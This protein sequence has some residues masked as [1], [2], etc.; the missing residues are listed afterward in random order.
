MFCVLFPQYSKISFEFWFST[1]W[2]T[3]SSTLKFS[4]YPVHN[5]PPSSSDTL[6]YPYMNAK[7][8]LPSASTPLSCWLSC[9]R[10]QNVVSLIIRVSGGWR[11]VVMCASISAYIE[12]PKV[13]VAV[14]V[15]VVV[16]TRERG[17]R[18]AFKWGTWRIS[19]LTGVGS[20]ADGQGD[21]REV[22]S[23][24]PT[25][26]TLRLRCWILHYT[27]KFVKSENYYFI[28]GGNNYSSL[29]AALKQEGEE[30]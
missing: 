30:K 22:G 21:E 14:V 7:V 20:Y 27:W 10:P 13:I 12:R 17:F 15:T 28:I 29:L 6:N 9:G 4:F 8:F 1:F 16:L 26:T 25:L 2:S 19:H 23:D 18:V 11:E 3:S 5:R 24:A